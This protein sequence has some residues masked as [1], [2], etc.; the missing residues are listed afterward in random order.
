M[1]SR[2][3]HFFPFFSFVLFTRLGKSRTNFFF[4]AGCGNRRYPFVFLF[5]CH[6]FIGLFLFFRLEFLSLTRVFALLSFFGPYGL[7]WLFLGL[8][9]ASL[10][11][12]NLAEFL[13]SVC[14]SMDGSSCF[15][16]FLN[17]LRLH[18]RCDLNMDYPLYI[19][20]GVSG[21][22]FWNRTCTNT[23]EKK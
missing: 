8:V 13:F 1:I 20:R 2:L 22:A 17:F 16:I 23:A 10:S 5:F 6:D 14:I 11:D 21:K 9:C 15:L 3:R 12:L 18:V 19:Y 4:H 7:G